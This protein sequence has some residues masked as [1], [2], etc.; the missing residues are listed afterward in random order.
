MGPT[1]N[2]EETEYGPMLS[3]D[4][5]YLFF[6]STRSGDGD[7]YWMDAAIIE[8]HKPKNLDAS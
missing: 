8:E 5:K 6:T 7:I 1:I 2:S 3:P 4:G